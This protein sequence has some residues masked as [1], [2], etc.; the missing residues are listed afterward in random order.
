MNVCTYS[1]EWREYERAARL[2]G[3]APSPRQR[4]ATTNPLTLLFLH[5]SPTLPLPSLLRNQLVLSFTFA[6]PPFQ[7]D[8]GWC[9]GHPQ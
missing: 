7:V 4:W 3:A 8:F 9:F 1:L 5:H 2:L 6:T